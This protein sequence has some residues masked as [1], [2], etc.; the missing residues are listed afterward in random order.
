MLMTCTDAIPSIQPSWLPGMSKFPCTDGNTPLL[1]Y[2]CNFCLQFAFVLHWSPSDALM[3]IFIA[4]HKQRP[5]SCCHF[6]IR[7]LDNDNCLSSFPPR[8]GGHLGPAQ[9]PQR[10]LESASQRH[11]ACAGQWDAPF[12]KTA[13]LRLVLRSF[14][15]K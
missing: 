1:A 11:L 2:V 7:D 4:I 10:V 12:R 8:G 6:D 3:K 13:G 14:Q 9:W 15:I 5:H